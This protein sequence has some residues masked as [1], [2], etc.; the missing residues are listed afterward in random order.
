MWLILLC[1]ITT[2]TISNGA[3]EYFLE[4][5]VSP[6]TKI[7]VNLPEVVTILDPYYRKSHKYFFLM[8][9]HNIFYMNP[10]IGALFSCIRKIT[11]NDCIR[12]GLL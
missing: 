12:I 7:V 5:A 3:E 8:I 11:A 4:K 2:C 1:I 9:K 10:T 6:T